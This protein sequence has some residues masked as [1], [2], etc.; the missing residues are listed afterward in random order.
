[1]PALLWREGRCAG[2]PSA[3]PTSYVALIN[4]QGGGEV[5]EKGEW[6]LLCT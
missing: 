3:G 2:E 1:M 6:W 4:L 5:E